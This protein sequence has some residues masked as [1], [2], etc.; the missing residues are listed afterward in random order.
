MLLLWDTHS[1]VLSKPGGGG[2]GD[3][4]LFVPGNRSRD[5]GGL[6]FWNQPESHW[7]SES[8]PFP[9]GRQPSLLSCRNIPSLTLQAFWTLGLTGSGPALPALT[10]LSSPSLLSPVLSGPDLHPWASILLCGPLPCSLSASPPISE[11]QSPHLRG[12]VGGGHSPQGEKLERTVNNRW[13]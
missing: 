1:V 13:Q 4:G 11:T 3:E 8:C 6:G 12:W 10:A 5:S 9:G 7:A 2:T